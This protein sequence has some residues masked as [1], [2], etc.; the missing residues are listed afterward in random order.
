MILRGGLLA[1]LDPPRIDR[2][3][4]RLEVRSTHG[5]SGFACALGNGSARQ[6]EARQREENQ[7][8]GASSHHHEVFENRRRRRY[9][10]GYWADVA[11]LTRPHAYRRDALL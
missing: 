4:L 10:G 6:H 2:A 9:R 1:S 3:D 5:D 11:G 8:P 7:S